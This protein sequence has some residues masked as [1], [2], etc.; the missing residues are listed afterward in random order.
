MLCLPLKLQLQSLIQIISLWKE[1]FLLYWQQAFDKGHGA[2]TSMLVRPDHFAWLPV[3]VL[4]KDPNV[5][6]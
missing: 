6:E 4:V 3:N 1:S 2:A 5:F